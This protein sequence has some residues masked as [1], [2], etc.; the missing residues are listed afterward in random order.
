[1]RRMVWITL[2]ILCCLTACGSNAEPEETVNMDEVLKINTVVLKKELEGTGHW[3]YIEDE[4]REALMYPKGSGLW[5]PDDGGEQLGYDD[6]FIMETLQ[7][8]EIRTMA[9][10]RGN[11]Y[12]DIE[13][14]GIVEVSKIEPADNSIR[15]VNTTFGGWIEVDSIKANAPYT[16]MIC[17]VGKKLASMGTHMLMETDT[18]VDREYTIEVKACSHDGAP[19][20]TAVLKLT[21]IPDPAYPWETIHD[22]KYTDLH[23][24]GEERTRFCSIELSYTYNEMHIMNGEAGLE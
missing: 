15:L 7:P 24:K 12:I 6:V 14:D 3:S 8:G 16:V 18:L 17:P 2:A 10:L 1:M 11:L 20:I 5:I 22:G 23:Q 21:A 4:K 13:Y 19:I 9:P